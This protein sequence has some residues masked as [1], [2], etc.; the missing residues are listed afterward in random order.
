MSKLYLQKENRAIAILIIVY[1]VGL[2]GIGANIHDSFILL[3]PLNLLLSLGLVLWNHPTWNRATYLFLIGCFLAGYGIEVVGIQTGL[4]FGS[5]T[6]GP[7][8]GYQ[9]WETPLM[10]GVN[11][12]MLVYCIGATLNH[13]FLK[14]KAILLKAIVGALLLLFL[15]ILIE[16]VAIHY[17]F[18]T[19]EAIAVPLQNYLA[20]YLIALVML[21]SFY[22]FVGRVKN[23]VAICLLALQFIFFGILLFLR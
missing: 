9:I 8:L 19:W 23:K 4:I 13:S 12:V 18:W 15:D 14:D 6:Y 3:T 1:A 21:L 10:I 2:V 11:W 20:W 22:Y 7:V 16:P 17:D 5:Y